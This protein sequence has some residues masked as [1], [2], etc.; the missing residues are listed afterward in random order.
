MTN[1]EKR[2]RTEAFRADI[3][4]VCRRHKLT[5]VPYHVEYCEYCSEDGLRIEPCEPYHI[6]DATMSSYG[7][8]AGRF[9]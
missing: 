6:T 8:I 4:D 1:V 3:L 5:L 9:K 2:T 7:W